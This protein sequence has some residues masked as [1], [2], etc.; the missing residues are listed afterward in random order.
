M[1]SKEQAT[2]VTALGTPLNEQGDLLEESFRKH[3][4]NQ[5]EYGMDG[6]LVAGTMGCMPCLKRSTYLKS[7]QVACDQ[8]AGKAKIM[9]GVGDNSIEKTSQRIDSLKGLKVDVVVATTPYYY[10]STQKDLLYYF[11]KIADKSPFPLYLYDL[12][13]VTKAKIEL[14]TALKLSQHPNIHGAKCSHDP[15]YV[16]ILAQMT[17]GTDFEIIHGQYDFTDV[18]LIYGVTA[19]V[20]G[21]YGIMPSWLKEIKDAYAKKDFE[22]IS[23]RQLTMTALRNAFIQLNVFPAFT[24]AM[25]LLGFE[26][27][28]HPSH[29]APLHENGKPKVK[30]LLQDAQLL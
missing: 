30:K 6:F 16:K 1:F 25:N 14:Q 8:A 27:S 13:Q 18:F 20:D 3:I 15:I 21:F 29:L 2:F 10:V 24:V 7:A 17:A 23:Q 28:F 5:L 19:S 12:P 4:D 11:T 9:V 22:K 26:G